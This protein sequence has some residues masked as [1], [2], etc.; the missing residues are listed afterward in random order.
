M[1][2][3]TG[4][5]DIAMGHL[6]SM[7]FGQLIGAPLK[8]TVEAQ[9][10]AAQT[11][12]DFIDAVGLNTKAN[13]DKKAVNVSFTYED[14][15]GRTRRLTG[16]LL[17]ILPIP[18]IEITSFDL[19]FKAKINASGSTLQADTSSQTS[20]HRWGVSAG[21]AGKRFRASGYY[22][23]GVSSKK[24]SK[25]TQESKYSV[26]YTMDINIHAGQAGMPSGMAAILKILEETITAQP[27]PSLTVTPKGKLEIKGSSGSVTVGVTA[28]KA[29][30]TAQSGAEI[31]AKTVDGDD[32]WLSTAATTPASGSVDI[33]LEGPTALSAGV[34]DVAVGAVV[35]G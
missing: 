27:T 14:A 10:I 7:D 31:T 22:A 4:S 9:A 5:S 19:Q 6:S 1:S 17:V 8:A 18:F 15:D 32:S 30:G 23:G 3:L 2:A 33:S 16:P 21:Y 28:Q 24:D 25:A 34:Y 13:G 11:T 20:A 29:D 26:E 12:V 35:D